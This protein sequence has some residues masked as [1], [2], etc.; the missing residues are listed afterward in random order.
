MTTCNTLMNFEDMLIKIQS[1]N[2]VSCMN[3]LYDIL[4]NTNY[5][6]KE[7]ISGCLCLGWGKCHYKCD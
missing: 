1:Q 6:D 5:N 4:E 3:L 7:Q 2:L